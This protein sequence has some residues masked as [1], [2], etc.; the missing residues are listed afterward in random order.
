MKKETK[1][2][3]YSAGMCTNESHQR[4]DSSEK[5]TQYFDCLKYALRG[6]TTHSNP[7]FT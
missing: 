2:H 5:Q 6:V 4:T 3:R 7:F 1:T